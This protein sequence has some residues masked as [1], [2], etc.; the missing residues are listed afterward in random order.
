MVDKI[1]NQMTLTLKGDCEI[2]VMRTFDAP[3]S[4]VFEAMTRCEHLSNWW[5]PRGFALIS[6]ELDLRPG[7]AYRFVQ[8]APDGSVH[9]FHGVYR[10][11]A[12]P[13]RLVFTQIYEPFA[14]S[15]V[16][17]T[18]TLT[19]TDGKTLL[20]QTLVFDSMESRDGMI[21]SGME[22]GEVESFERLDE[23][24]AALAAA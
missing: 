8:Q 7:G 19:E 11:I 23:V 5:G 3:R 14:N 24:L 22:R 12:A 2:A 4:L 21:A 6:C 13:E 20:S 16:V 9:P 1:A 15:E 18:G 17:V 10:E